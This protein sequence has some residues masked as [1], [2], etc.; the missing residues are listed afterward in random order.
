MTTLP[1]PTY[2]KVM[3]R[4]VVP[5]YINISTNIL[6]VF[7]STNTS[8]VSLWRRFKVAFILLRI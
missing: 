6:L 4:I 7:V 1:M 5:I 8:H 3:K 2:S